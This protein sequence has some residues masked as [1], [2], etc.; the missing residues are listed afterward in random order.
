MI[1]NPV[2]GYPVIIQIFKENDETV[3]FAQTD[4]SSRW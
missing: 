1:A 3:H 4:V 2:E